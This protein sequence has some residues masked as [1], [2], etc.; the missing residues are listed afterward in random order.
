MVQGANLDR[1]NRME[2]A[3]QDSINRILLVLSNRLNIRPRASETCQ[4]GDSD[5]WV[6]P[7]KPQQRTYAD[8]VRSGPS[9]SDQMRGE[10]LQANKTNQHASAMAR[11]IFFLCKINNI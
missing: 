10:R 11:A 3:V 5:E 4:E 1:I 2:K 9:R 6:P 8:A 7:M